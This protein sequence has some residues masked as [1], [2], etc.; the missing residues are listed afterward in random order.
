MK[1]LLHTIFDIMNFYTCNCFPT[2][3]HFF[4]VH[5][6]FQC[7]SMEV[8][9]SILLKAQILGDILNPAHLTVMDMS[10]PSYTGAT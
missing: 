6:T 4:Q 3:M 9:S 5:Q 8:E 2:E 1:K 10:E 7:R